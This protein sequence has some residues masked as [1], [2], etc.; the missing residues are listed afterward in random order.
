MTAKVLHLIL[1]FCA[2][3]ALAG[4][5]TAVAP[6]VDY[7]EFVEDKIDVHVVRVD[8]SNDHIMVISTRQ[9]EKGLKVSDY[10]KKNSAL[11][12]VNGD[13]FDDKF[14]PIGLVIGPC[15]QW[16]GTRDTGREG[17]LAAGTHRVEVR[18]QSE[19][20]DPPEPWVET[21]VSGWPLLIRNCVPLSATTLPGS[22]AFTRAPHARTAAGVSKDGKTLYLVV[23]DGGRAN[24]P[25]FTLA[26]L[27]AFMSSRL[28]A[29]W[30]LN[31]DGGGS[32]AMW[33]GDHIVNRPSDGVERRVGDHLAVI[34]K[35]D[36]T[37]C[38]APMTGT[39]T[40]KATAQPRAGSAVAVRG[41]ERQV[42]I[43][44]AH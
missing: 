22:D 2:T 11:V 8:V 37:G 7:Q 19:V 34:L 6:G 3:T 21:A 35:T 43:H 31:L 26:E 36:Y 25:G 13:Y 32:S 5:W 15:G 28:D 39:T 41:T 12:A 17:V 44:A 14:N 4:D 24:A 16:P 27:A 38:D 10:A 40:T 18:T 30:A 1:F 23:A 33:V 42:A 9:S 29:R 20:M